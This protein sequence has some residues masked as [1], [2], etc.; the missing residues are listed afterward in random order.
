MRIL[1]TG[2]KNGL[3]RYLHENFPGAVGWDRDITEKEKEEVKRQGVDV[4]VH[5][6]FHSAPEVAFE[7]LFPYLQDNVFLANELAS[8]PRKKFIFIS[9]VD[10]YPRGGARHTED[11]VIHVNDVHGIYGITKLMAESI[12]QAQ[13]PNFLIMRCS[14]FLGPYMRKN[15][16]KKIREDEKPAVTLTPDSEC[17]YVLYEDV[18]KF[19]QAAVKKDI[20]GIYNIASSENIKFAEVADMF[21]K[22]VAFGEYKYVVGNIDN[23]KATRVHPAFQKTSKQVIQE[24]ARI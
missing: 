4:V 8:V 23:T 11:E 15:S 14:A 1:I 20:Q 16:L 13:C 5:C 22:Q 2:N 24:Y 19:V 3:G 6:A 7:M 17:N 21:K 12:V 10:V 9:S 18:L